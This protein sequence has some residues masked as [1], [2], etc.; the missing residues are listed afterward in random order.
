MLRIAIIL[1]LLVFAALVGVSMASHPGQVMIEWFGTRIETTAFFGAA[2]MILLLA[3]LL[4]VV[5]FLI[6]LLDAPGRIGKAAE[7]ARRKKGQEALALG[8]IAAEDGRIAVLLSETSLKAGSEVAEKLR[9]RIDR[10]TCFIPRLRQRVVVHLPAKHVAID[11]CHHLVERTVVTQAELAAG[12]R[13][14]AL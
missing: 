2:V 5:N 11:R 6:L 10:T 14:A 4:P 3:F 13:M 12:I 9:R 8:L 7:R 1:V